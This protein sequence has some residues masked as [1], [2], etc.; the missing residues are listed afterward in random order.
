MS[1]TDA[2][3]PE[4]PEG[5]SR[6]PQ[7]TGDAAWLRRADGLQPRT[8]QLERVAR[9]ARAI[10]RRNVDRAIRRLEGDRDLTDRERRAVEALAA[11]LIAGVLDNPATV[12]AAA[13]AA[14]DEETLQTGAGLLLD[15]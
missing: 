9:N 7:P 10:E 13:A 12:L 4:Q 6:E 14:G 8:R 11:D 2:D 1:T 15:E 3:D 5:A